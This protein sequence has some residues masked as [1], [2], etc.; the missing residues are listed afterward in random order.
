MDNNEVHY[1]NWVDSYKHGGSDWYDQILAG[2][3]TY[4]MALGALT[5]IDKRIA[6]IK[7]ND[8]LVNILLKGNTNSTKETF[9]CGFPDFDIIIDAGYGKN[10]I[11]FDKLADEINNDSN[12]R[13]K[14][15]NSAMK[16]RS[17]IQKAINTKYNNK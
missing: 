6:R 8:P 10:C 17:N 13:K 3:M 2:E 5:D 12:A 9:V 1:K 14:L 16:I 15:L 11:D 7:N 4:K